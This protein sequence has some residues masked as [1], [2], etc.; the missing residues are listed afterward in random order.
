MN[1][2]SQGW[3]TEQMWDAVLSAP[4]VTKPDTEVIYSDLGYLALGHD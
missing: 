3:D 1:L 4:L 2:H